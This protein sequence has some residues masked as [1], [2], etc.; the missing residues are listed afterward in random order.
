MADA[1]MAPH[2]SSGQ[3]LNVSGM[4]SDA[5]MPPH[6]SLGC[7]QYARYAGTCQSAATCQLWAQI[8]RQLHASLSEIWT[9]DANMPPHASPL[10]KLD[11]SAFYMPALGTN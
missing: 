3:K 2:A 8:G 4:T 9:A 6:A 11:V 1:N 10:Q 7:D 5:N